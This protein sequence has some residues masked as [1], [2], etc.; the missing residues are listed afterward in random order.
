[1]PILRGP[2]AVRLSVTPDLCTWT[3]QEVIA[4]LQVGA[5]L[6]DITAYRR[7]GLV[8][9]WYPENGQ[10]FA[11]EQAFLKTLAQRPHIREVKR[12]RV[13]EALRLEMHQP[14][15][16]ADALR[17]PVHPWVSVGLAG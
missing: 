10:T 15:T 6:T 13:R 7:Q 8:R 9:G 16:R 11:S 1:M 2:F 5:G 12:E 3:F 14:R 17:V 4:D